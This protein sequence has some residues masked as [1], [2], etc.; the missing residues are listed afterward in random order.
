[1]KRIS[2][3]AILFYGFPGGYRLAKRG[4]LTLSSGEGSP[5]MYSVQNWNL[6][7]QA[8]SAKYQI[9]QHWSLEPIALLLMF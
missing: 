1:M 2:L 4:H 6:G 8:G 7:R 9:Y 5:I 3:A